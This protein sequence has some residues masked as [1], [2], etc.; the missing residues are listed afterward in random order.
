MQIL[1]GK[2]TTHIRKKVNELVLGYNT[3]V[4]NIAS[5]AAGNI[6][7]TVTA[8]GTDAATAKALSASKFLHKVLGAD[9]AVGVILPAGVIGDTHI[10]VNTVDAVLKIYPAT[11]EKISS[12]TASAAISGTALYTY[13]FVY[14]GGTVGWNA[15]KLLVA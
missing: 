5:L 7:E 14:E 8:L 4:T 13:I 10:V 6:G 11:G 9:A 2:A 15:T 12:G 1:P 3:N